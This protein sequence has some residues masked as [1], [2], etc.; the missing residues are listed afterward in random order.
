MATVL[1]T[2]VKNVIDRVVLLERQAVTESA[3]AV[4]YIMHAQESFPYWTNSPTDLIPR[5]GSKDARKFELDILMRLVIDHVTAGYKGERQT[6]AWT[7]LGDIVFY[8]ALHPK[9]DLE[10]QTALRYLDPTGATIR[11]RRGLQ[12]APLGATQQ[13]CL[14]FDLIV[15]LNV[16]TRVS[17]EE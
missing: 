2:T 10:G 14:D 15:P 12:V 16:S 9:L 5:E 11:P 1:G 3:N 4:P 13:L 6:K 17:E 7:Y 8:F